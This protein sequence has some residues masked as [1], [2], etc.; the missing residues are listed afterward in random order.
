MTVSRHDLQEL[1]I[2]GTMVTLERPDDPDAEPIKFYVKKLT[3]GQQERAVRKAQ[4]CRATLMKL[5]DRPDDDLDKVLLM[6]DVDAIGDRDDKIKYLAAA[7]VA[8]ERSSIEQELSETDKWGEDGY[9]QGL[10]D[11]WTEERQDA[12][13][14][15]PEGVDEEIRRNFEALK[16]FSTELENRLQ[17]ERDSK[18]LDYDRLDESVLGRK[19][20]DLLLEHKTGSEW[21]RTFRNYQILYGVLD[22]ETKTPIFD[23]I[24]QIEDVPLEVY[25]VFLNA[26]TGL[27]LPPVEVKS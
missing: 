20:F 1:F 11:A 24:S 25:K 14:E 13:A 18:E 5:W 21:L 16:E 27:S 6:A 9:L 8:Q 7:K 4:A 17:R 2:T 10:V 15:D 23:D 3:P 22:P 12:W 19:L 26:I